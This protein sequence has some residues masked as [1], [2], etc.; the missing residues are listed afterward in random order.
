MSSDPKFFKKS[1]ED[2]LELLTHKPRRISQEKCGPDAKVCAPTL[3][4]CQPEFKPI[5][6]PVCYPSAAE[7]DSTNKPS[8]VD[9]NAANCPPDSAYICRPESCTPYDCYPEIL[10]PSCLPDDDPDD[11]R[12]AQL[13][14]NSNR[15]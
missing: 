10:L 2:D 14:R 6:K 12:R 15:R 3:Y 7:S 9:P 5:C 4:P 13:P 8:E 1:H 11:D